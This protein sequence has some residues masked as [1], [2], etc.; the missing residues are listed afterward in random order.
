[1]KFSIITV[2]YNSERTIRDTIES[3]LEQSYADIEHIIVDG[4]STDGTLSIIEEYRDRIARIVSEPDTGIYDAMNKGIG[5]ATGDFVGILN[6]DDTFVS[7]DTI[8]KLATFLEAN[9]SLDGAYADV[10]YV[11]RNRPDR[12]T[13]FYSSK[14]FS[15]R[16]LR[17]GIM[18]PHATFYVRRTLFERWGAYKA[19]YPIVADFELI[20]RF[21]VKGAVLGRHP[22]IMVKMRNGG[23][24]NAGFR[25][26]VRQNFDI[27]RACR[28]NG[29]YTNIFLLMLKI[30]SKLMGY[31]RRGKTADVLAERKPL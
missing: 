24:S 20:T 11:D 14:D 4:R 22:R 19:G 7:P 16:Q 25:S 9:P 8:E 18:F 29:I 23:I 15:P 17:I 13:R 1:M 27:V 30:P 21:I 10:V 2:C 31:V 6:S 26:V 28:E 3:V 5:M 12:V